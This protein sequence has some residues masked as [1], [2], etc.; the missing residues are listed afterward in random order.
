MYSVL[1]AWS[2]GQIGLFTVHVVHA[3]FLRAITLTKT[4]THSIPCGSRTTWSDRVQPTVLATGI[5]REYDQAHRCLKK[6]RKKGFDTILQLFQQCNIFRESQL[7]SGLDEEPCRRL[8]IVALEDHSYVSTH[9][10]GEKEI[11]HQHYI[12][13]DK[14]VLCDKDQTILTPYEH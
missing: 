3:C 2:T 6:A 14:L 8:D 12:F 1:F 10:Q 7:A 9:G 4:R 11:G 13:K 5:Q